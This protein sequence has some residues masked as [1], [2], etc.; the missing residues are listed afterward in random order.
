[1]DN[2]GI[3]PGQEA[4][5]QVTIVEL[6][7]MFDPNG[8]VIAINQLGVKQ[9]GLVLLRQGLPKTLDVLRIEHSQVRLIAGQVSI[10]GQMVKGRPPVGPG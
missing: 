3:G 5:R 6:V 9:V 2:P 7:E 1:M 8:L 4:E 10:V